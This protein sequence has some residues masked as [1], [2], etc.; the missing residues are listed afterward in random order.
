[1]EVVQYILVVAVVLVAVGWLFRKYLFPS[2]KTT[3][4]GDGDCGCH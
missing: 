2:K 3:G 1:M 4:C